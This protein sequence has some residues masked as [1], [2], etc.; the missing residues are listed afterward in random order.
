MTARRFAA[1]AWDIDG[2]LVD[3]EPLHHRSLLA[4]T[5]GFSV[6]LGDLPDQAFRGIHMKDVWKMLRPRLP[7]DLEERV[8]LEAIDA[9]YV[10]HRHE[11]VAIPGARDTIARLAAAGIPQACVSNSSRPVV[12]AN[13]D[14]LG[15]AGSIAFSIS[16]DDVV[17]G[18]PDPEPYARAVARLGVAAAAT[19]A[20]E[21]S[22]SG[23]RSARAAGLWAVGFAAPGAR[24]EGCDQ[25]ID[26]LAELVELIGS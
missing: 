25:A 9:H 18:K 17:A 13:I 7:A 5:G 23:I 1:V 22:G 6:D 20:V 3:S 21:D 11:L 15:I 16:L 14:A 19:V 26:R 24:I 12:D 4:A 8:W 2:T 10:A